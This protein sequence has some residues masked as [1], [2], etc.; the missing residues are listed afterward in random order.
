MNKKDKFS[1]MIRLAKSRENIARELVA[2]SEESYQYGSPWT[3]EQFERVIEQDH[4]F[5]LVVEI[6]KEIVGFLCGGMTPFEAE[7]YNIAISQNHKRAGLASD[8]LSDM[9][10]ILV[11]NRIGEI[12]LE[13]RENNI[14]AI[15]LY[16]KMG[17]E[18]VGLRKDYYT[19]P[20]EDAIILKCEIDTV[21]GGR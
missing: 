12:F 18:L 9:K 17:F 6:N 21:L 8:L 2:I 20:L 1:P 13:V 3:I 5:V 14:G 4:V 10:R 7:I 19:K 15:K 11:A 16:K